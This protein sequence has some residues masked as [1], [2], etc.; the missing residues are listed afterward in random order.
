[1]RKKLHFKKKTEMKIYRKDD[2]TGQETCGAIN[3]TCY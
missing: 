1:M 2:K 3:Y